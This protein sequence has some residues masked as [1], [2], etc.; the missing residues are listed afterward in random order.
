MQEWKR[1]TSMY[2]LT[3]WKNKAYF[4]FL[5]E[6]KFVIFTSILLKRGDVKVANL[7]KETIYECDYCSGE[8]YFQ[9]LL[10]GS[11]T[12]P[13]CKGSGKKLAA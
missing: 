11:E 8:G 3:M 1:K 5:E 6:G 13:C 9:L 12:C 4:G 2:S 10:G 7:S